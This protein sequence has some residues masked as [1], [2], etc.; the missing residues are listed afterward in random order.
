MF[1]ATRTTKTNHVLVAVEV[2]SF[3]V[4]IAQFALM[5]AAIA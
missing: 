1:A 5:A 4:C 2:L 3:A